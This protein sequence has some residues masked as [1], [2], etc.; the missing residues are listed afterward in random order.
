MIDHQPITP[1]FSLKREYPDY[2]SAHISMGTWWTNGQRYLDPDMVHHPILDRKPAQQTQLIYPR[3]HRLARAYK[4]TLL[5]EV[6]PSE[7]I[8]WFGNNLA[9]TIREDGDGYKTTTFTGDQAIQAAFKRDTQE[10]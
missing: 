1:D 3:L 7:S 2:I 5:I 9:F 6:T 10:Q 8:I 4:T